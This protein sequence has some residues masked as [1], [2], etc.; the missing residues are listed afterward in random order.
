MNIVIK[1]F[2]FL[3][4]LTYGALYYLLFFPLAKAQSVLSLMSDDGLK[5]TSSQTDSFRV[6]SK[7]IQC[8]PKR[9]S[10]LPE[11]EITKIFQYC[12]RYSRWTLL[13]ALLLLYVFGWLFS[14]FSKNDQI[15]RPDLYTFF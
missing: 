8:S 10:D 1:G 9:Y 4:F 15:N 14:L 6:L 7:K 3:K 5:K 11:R 12:K 2:N 13:P